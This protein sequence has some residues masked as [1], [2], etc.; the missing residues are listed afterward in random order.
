MERDFSRISYPYD[1]ANG[2]WK[3]SGGFLWSIN[4]LITG[5][6]PCGTVL[7]LY[8][9]PLKALNNDVRRNLIDP[10]EELKT[11]FEERDVPFPQIHVQTRSGDTPS[12]ERQKMMR[13]P[14]EILITTPESL[15][16][17]LTSSAAQK[18]LSGL[19]VVILD[20]IHAVAANKRGVHLIS[21]I[22]RLTLINGEFQRIGLSATVHTPLVSCGVIYR[23][24]LCKKSC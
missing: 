11:F 9:S 2:K 17:L 23:W 3:N 1:R 7:V 22:E 13:R 6:W 4:Q 24:F 16:L 5:D 15:N 12:S 18:I 14:P 10:L 8:I 21:A 19:S 20:E